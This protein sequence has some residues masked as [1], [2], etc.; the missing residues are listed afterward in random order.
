MR[1]TLTSLLMVACSSAA[2]SNRTDD[3][4]P[5]D[6]LT[7]ERPKKYRRVPKLTSKSR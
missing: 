6:V 5:H 7:P 2:G 1:K 4:S 3:S